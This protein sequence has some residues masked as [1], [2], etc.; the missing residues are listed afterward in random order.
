MFHRYHIEGDRHVPWNWSYADATER[1]AA[2][3]F[4]ALDV[5]KWARQ[6]DDG[7]G[8]VSFWELLTYSPPTWG[9]VASGGA[10]AA[11]DAEVA[12][13]LAAEAVIAAN[14][15]T[16]TTD[17]TT[18][19]AG[20]QSQI[21]AL[22]DAVIYKTAIDCSANPNYPAADKG[23]LYKVS[24]A[25][26][27]GGGSGPNVEVGDSLIC[28]TDSTAAGNHATVGAN[29]DIYQANIDGAVIGPSTATDEGF[30]LFDGISGRL[31]KNS[32]A[33]VPISKGGTGAATALLAALALTLPTVTIGGSGGTIDID[34]SLGFR[35]KRTLAANTT[36]TFSNLLDGQTIVVKLTN[37]GANYTV[38]W[39]ASVHWSYGFTPVQSIGAVWDEYTF[40]NDGGVISGSVVQS[41]S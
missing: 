26:K 29:W 31:V 12:R 4:V 20:L 17:R 19:D 13:A 30:V 32:A 41:F 39:P 23:F 15:G 28:N 34:W 5:G 24:V 36:F 21:D 1:E 35:F 16:E 18:A 38:T 10:A 11:L 14:L 33:V 8:N 27:I 37:T 2:T 40:V 9:L 25:G 3:G 7:D 22:G 6:A